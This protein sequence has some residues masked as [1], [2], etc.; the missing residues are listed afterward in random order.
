MANNI[1]LIQGTVAA[2]KILQNDLSA[3]SVTMYIKNEDTN[4]V[5]SSSDT[6]VN[7]VAN[8]EFDGLDTSTPGV[9]LYQV[10]ENLSGG[11]VAK[12]GAFDCDKDGDCDFNYI[13]ICESLDGGIS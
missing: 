13:I 10:N 4:E 12:Y 8:I 1:T 5:I 2:F 9:Y 6:Y 3:T 11:G 7:G